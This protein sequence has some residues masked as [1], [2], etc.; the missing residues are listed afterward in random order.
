MSA[1][2]HKLYL[3]PAELVIAEAPTKVITVLGSCVSVTLFSPKLKIGAICHAVLPH[4]KSA[5]PTKFVDQS[6]S[7]MLKCF[8]SHGVEPKDL[9]AKVFGGSDMF[10]LLDPNGSEFTIG[11]QNIRAAKR[12]LADAG[13]K[14][15]AAD[16]G[17]RLG[18][19]LVFYSHTG[20]VYLKR[21]HKEQLPRQ[22]RRIAAVTLEEIDFK[23]PDDL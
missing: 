16:T 21:I 4:G 6:V 12:C 18:R 9:V 23:L 7:Y 15:A 14:L 20:D 1:G 5:E 13:L 2:L 11:T 22:V 3:N 10:V 19:K 17:G 8:R